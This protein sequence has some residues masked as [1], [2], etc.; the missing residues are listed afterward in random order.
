[1]IQAG[2]TRGGAGLPRRSGD[3]T[4]GPLSLRSRAQRSTHT[5]DTTDHSPHTDTR[6]AGRPGTTAGVRGCTGSGERVNENLLFVGSF[7]V[8]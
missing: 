1:M 4:L 3:K 7:D 8:I 5:H 2:E 6:T